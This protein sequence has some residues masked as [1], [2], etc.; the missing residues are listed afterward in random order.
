MGEV[1]G[2]HGHRI[3]LSG[4][5]PVGEPTEQRSTGFSVKFSD[6]YTIYLLRQAVYVLHSPEDLWQ[7]SFKMFQAPECILSFLCIR[8]PNDLHRQ[9][10]SL[11]CSWPRQ[12]F[13]ALSMQKASSRVVHLEKAQVFPCLSHLLPDSLV[14]S[15]ACE[16]GCAARPKQ[17]VDAVAR[18]ER[19]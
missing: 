8:C 3:E 4:A 11:K 14:Q 10:R 19:H 12:L 2:S 1:H 6:A 17:R 18:V 5:M 15:V 7:N 16:H 13:V 9:G